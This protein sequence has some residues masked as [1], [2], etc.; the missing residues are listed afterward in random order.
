MASTYGYSGDFK[1]AVSV[2][3]D[4]LTRVFDAVYQHLASGFD[5]YSVDM[6]AEGSESISILIGVN[7]ADD[8]DS[9]DAVELAERAIAEAFKSA[10]AIAETSSS[11]AERMELVGA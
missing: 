8:Q 4:E 6:V 2:S 7:V 3:K 10:G 1:P 11:K 5:F 9:D